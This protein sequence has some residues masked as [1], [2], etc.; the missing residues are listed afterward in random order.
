M[1][2]CSHIAFASRSGSGRGIFFALALVAVGS[3]R[4]ADYSTPAIA[5]TKPIILYDGKTVADLS[6]FY[7]WLGPLGYTDPNRVFTVVDAL[8]GAP[9]IRVSGQDYG[10]IVTRQNYRDYRMVLEY[11]WGAATWGDRKSRARNSGILLHCQGEDGSYRPDFK[12][13]WLLSVEYEILEGRTGDIILVGGAKRGSKDKIL[14]TLTMRA[15]PGDFYWDPKGTPR[16]F[17]SGKGHLHW[18][19]RDRAWKDELGF[20]GPQD[21]ERPVG[22][23]NRAEIVAKGGDLVYFLNGTKILEATN[24]S[25]THGRLLFQSE[26]AEIFFRRIELHPLD[27]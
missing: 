10:G 9:A 13:P 24:G 19:G 22:Q 21:V 11:R 14:P 18:Y 16:E 25:L 6:Q 26:G 1:T 20:R 5:P 7:T 2:S 4:G 23:W 15:Q 27:R 8:D 17:V 12:G 3:V